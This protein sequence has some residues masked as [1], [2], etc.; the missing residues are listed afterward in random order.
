MYVV[1]TVCILRLVVCIE[2]LRSYSTRVLRARTVRRSIQCISTTL[3]IV[4][5][6]SMNTMNIRVLLFFMISMHIHSTTLASI[7]FYKR[8]HFVCILFSR[9]K[10]CDASYFRRHPDT[11]MRAAT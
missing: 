4:L 6:S 2:I 11:I 7:L 8:K 9:V 10:F 3:C 5:R 1:H